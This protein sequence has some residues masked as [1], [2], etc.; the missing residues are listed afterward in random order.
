MTMK[1][2][3]IAE[4]G[5]WRIVARENQSGNLT[6]EVEVNG[7]RLADLCCQEDGTV[8]VGTTGRPWP[9]GEKGWAMP[10]APS[11]DWRRYRFAESE[12]AATDG[13]EPTAESPAP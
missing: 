10:G 6:V 13:L 5:P 9:L 12:D 3:T 4:I 1:H 7:E 2:K 8:D 11:E